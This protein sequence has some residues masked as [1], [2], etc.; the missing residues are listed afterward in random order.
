[1]HDF[2]PIVNI[3]GERITLGPLSKDVLPTITRWIND[4]HALRTLGT[5]QP[6]PSTF[7]NEEEWYAS[8][9]SGKAG[10][11]FLI[12]ER[13]SHVPIGSTSLHAI[14]YRNRATTFGILIGEHTARGQGYGTEAARLMLDYAFNVLGLHSVSLA[15]AEFNLAGRRAYEKAGFREC[16]RLRERLWLAARMWDEIHMDCLATEFESPVLAALFAPDTPK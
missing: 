5:G 2:P 9:I 16:G 14:D 4:F 3:V 10:I 12:R 6:G 13:S 8:A 1:M 15:V 11:N 7:E